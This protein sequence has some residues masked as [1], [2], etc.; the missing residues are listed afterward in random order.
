MGIL[1]F[2]LVLNAVLFI[3]ALI[4]LARNRTY[5]SSGGIV[6]WAVIVLAVPL[7]GPVLWFVSGR[8]A[9]RNSPNPFPPNQLANSN[10]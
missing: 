1:G 2:L 7:L 4:S 8:R 6:V 5:I 10:D 3:S 9:A